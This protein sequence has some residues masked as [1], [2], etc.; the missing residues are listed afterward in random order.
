MEWKFEPKA[1]VAR[2]VG[3]AN[4]LHCRLLVALEMLRELGMLDEY[5]RLSEKFIQPEPD[6]GL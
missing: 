5:R 6:H 4:T 2:P 1:V 3:E